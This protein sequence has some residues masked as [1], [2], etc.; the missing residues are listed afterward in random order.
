M[1]KVL[2]ISP[3]FYRLMGSKYNG[4][5]LGLCYVSASLKKAGHETSIYNSD[6]SDDD[7]YLD[8]KQMYNSFDAYKL[9]YEVFGHGTIWEEI[10]NVIK[11]ESPDFVGI[12]MVTATYKSS[13]IVADITKRVNP[14]IKV[15]V[16]G[17][18]PTLD[19]FKT[20]EYKNFD[21]LVH[22]EG[23]DY[24]LVD[25]EIYSMVFKEKGLADMDAFPDREIYF[26]QTGKKSYIM[27]VRG[28]PFNCI[29]CATPKIW[30][31]KVK[32]RSVENVLEELQLINDKY[33]DILHFQDDTFTF[34]KERFL[35]ICRGMIDRQL[36]LNWICDTRLDRIDN[37]V[38]ES[39][40]ETGCSRIKVGVESGSNRILKQTNKGLSINLIKKRINLIKEIGLPL[41][42]YLMIGF[43]GETDEDVKKTIELAEWINAD[44]NSLSV[45][46]PYFGTALYE[47]NKHLLTKPNWEYFY[48]QSQQ[49][50]L[51]D[52]ISSK[53]IEEFF[54]LG[55]GGDR[56]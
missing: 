25:H 48:H 2:L 6:Y 15:I 31:K 9:A 24:E 41:T 29:Y 30:G 44:Y 14:E 26:N 46:T 3:P 50:V 45:V 21:S 38:L 10:E 27:T 32:W 5:S 33:N 1:S 34:D 56:K 51:N 47:E 42:I 55:E 7:P 40:K 8:Q 23:E 39:M 36:D 18:H 37:E 20:A 49:M 28:C 35:N 54:K 22:G 52:Q 17:V 11:Q 19:P 43:P 4:M 53:M 12:Q 13:Q 16:G